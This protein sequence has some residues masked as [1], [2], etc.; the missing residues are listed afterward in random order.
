[1]YPAVLPD[2]LS[3]VSAKFNGFPALNPVFEPCHIFVP[4]EYRTIPL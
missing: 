4:Q 3:S 2:D 1:M